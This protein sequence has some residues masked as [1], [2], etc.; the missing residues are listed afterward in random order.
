MS[1]IYNDSR[2][3]LIVIIYLP[4]ICSSPSFEEALVLSAELLSHEEH[5]KLTEV[6]LIAHLAK[7][8]LGE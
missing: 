1:V 4:P 6:S 3:L 7:L 5:P 2:N 8:D